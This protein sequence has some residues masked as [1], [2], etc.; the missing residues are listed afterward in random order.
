VQ[1]RLAAGGTRR[2]SIIY[3]LSSLRGNQGLL[4][5][6]SPEGGRLWSR[7]L[8]LLVPTAALH[9]DGLVLAGA[10]FESS[11]DVGTGPITPQGNLDVVLFDV[12]R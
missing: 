9:Q 12:A 11:V 6:Y 7:S 5:A 2:C 4:S 1:T 10:V 8:P 3:A